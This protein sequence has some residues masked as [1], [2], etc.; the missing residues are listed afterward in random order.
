MSRNYR[1][2][3]WK[4]DVLK[5]SIFAPEASFLGQISVLR[6]SNF[7]LSDPDSSSKETL[8]GQQKGVPV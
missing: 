7:Q 6:A 3:T 1:S 4:F 8:R 5:T 2:D